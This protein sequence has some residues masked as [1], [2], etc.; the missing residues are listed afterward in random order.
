MRYYEQNTVRGLFVNW[1]NDPVSALFN[2]TNS[3][4][5][6]KDVDLTVRRGERVGILGLNGSGKTSLC[7]CIAGMLHP[8]SGTVKIDGAVRAVFDANVGVLPELTGRENAR[9][10]ASLLFPE[11]KPDEIDAVAAE[12][13]EFSEL[14]AFLDVPF[15]T[16]SQGMRARLF[17]A[18]MTARPANL[19]ILDEIYDNTDQF[20]Q[21]KMTRR[22]NNF[23]ADADAVL[24]VSHSPDILKST[25]NRAI[26]LHESRIAY[27]G[28]VAEAL[29]AYDFLNGG[30]PE[31]KEAPVTPPL[32]PS[33]SARNSGTISYSD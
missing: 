4:H 26:V 22:L 6:L 31:F 33:L 8:V 15:E 13:M 24:F 23:I 9:L 14:G 7:R 11:A 29:A 21:K 5:V 17:L 1:I 30:F 10:I 28:S 32:P 12:A 19:L 25:C 2:P 3:L 16:Y 18:L 20:F 27:D